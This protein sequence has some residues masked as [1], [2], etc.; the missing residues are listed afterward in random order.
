MAIA[1]TLES[2][3]NDN[4]VNYSLVKHRRTLSALDSSSAAHLPCT[5]VVK[6]VM[7]V[8]NDGDYLMAGLSAGRRLSVLKLSELMGEA[9]HLVDEEALL[10]LFSDCE[11][12]AIPGIAEAYGIKMILDK[13][14]IDE[15]SVYIEGGDHC[16]LIRLNHLQYTPLLSGTLLGDISGEVIGSPSFGDTDLL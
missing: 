5:Q 12:G 7:L 3:L 1:I 14:L 6:S 4:H 10:S 16:H 2:F 15:E 11:E 13:P 8:S 9:Y